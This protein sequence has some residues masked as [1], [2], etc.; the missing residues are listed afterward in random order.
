M[1]ISLNL[2][3]IFDTQSKLDTYPTT[4]STT[5]ASTTQITTTTETDGAT[6]TKPGNWFK[7]FD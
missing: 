7:P 2:S 4:T 3:I 6:T 1:P 5:E